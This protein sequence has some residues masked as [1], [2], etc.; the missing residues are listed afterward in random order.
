MGREGGKLQI[1]KKRGKSR[2]GEPRIAA[3]ESTV[4]GEFAKK[5]QFA[6]RDC[7]GHARHRT[8][9]TKESSKEKVAGTASS[10]PWRGFREG[11]HIPAKTKG[12]KK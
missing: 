1:E 12:G 6:S 11:K 10:R 8:R 3:F 5:S 9:A 7:L 2:G 4:D